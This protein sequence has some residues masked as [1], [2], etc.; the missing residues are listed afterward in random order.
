MIVVTIVFF[1]KEKKKLLDTLKIRYGIL[2]SHM[3]DRS[4]Y[5]F[6]SCDVILC[7]I[8]WY[9]VIVFST[10]AVLNNYSFFYFIFFPLVLFQGRAFLL[11]LPS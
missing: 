4:Y 1:K 3:F 9:Y 11:F 6:T 2:F 5:E 7:K 8:M 10:H